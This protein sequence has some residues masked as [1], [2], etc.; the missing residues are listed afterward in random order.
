M[1]GV[2]CYFGEGNNCSWGV[3]SNWG[4]RDYGLGFKVVRGMVI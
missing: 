2:S 4:D 1:S 3:R